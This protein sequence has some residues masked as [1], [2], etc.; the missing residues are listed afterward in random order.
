MLKQKRIYPL[1]FESDKLI[2]PQTRRNRFWDKLSIFGECWEWDGAV[3]EQG[4]GVLVLKVSRFTPSIRVYAHR[5]A[6]VI[7]NQRDIPEGMVI[8]HTCEN[9]VCCN[10]LHLQCV[11]QTANVERYHANRPSAGV[12]KRGHPITTGKPCAECNR[13]RVAAWKASNPDRYREIQHQHDM[14]RGKTKRPL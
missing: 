7:A 12:C 2:D 13:V 8:D 1:F 14:K 11:T 4:Y 10:P 3:C 9:K 6:W 5:A